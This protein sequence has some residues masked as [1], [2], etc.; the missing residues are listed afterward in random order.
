MY[1]QSL[2]SSRRRTP[3]D[4]KESL[5]PYEQFIKDQY[6]EV[7]DR[8]H[9]SLIESGEAEFLNAFQVFQCRHC[10]SENFIKYGHT[11][12][13]VNRYLCKDC[14]RTFTITTGTIFEDHK[15]PYTEWVEQLLR[16][17][18]YESMSLASKNGRN[19]FTTT[20]YWDAKLFKI[21]DNYQENIVLFGNVQ[22]DE[23]YWDLGKKHR[24]LI[25]GKQYRGISRNK[26]CIAIGTDGTQTITIYENHQGKPTKEST[27]NAFNQHIQEGSV[28]IHDSERSHSILVSDLNLTE[29][30]YNSRD[31]IRLDDKDNPLREVNHACALLKAFL[32]SHSGF[33]R[34]ELQGYLDLF[35]FLMNPPAEPLEKVKVLL[36][37]SLY[38]P[39]T[40][41]YRDYYSVEPHD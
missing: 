31:L 24:Q 6:V 32:R 14:G 33:E 29:K 18:G 30:K 3:W 38:I 22:I 15:I 10:G 1:N 11:S 4:Y 16:I 28:L 25:D 26:M 13:G 36:V 23:T 20:K 39:E 37:S 12:N 19:S 5:S 41:R 2:T 21:L 7:F 35:A 34:D 17:I 27:W 40:L 9:Q 8:R